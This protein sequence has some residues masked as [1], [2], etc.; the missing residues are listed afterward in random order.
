MCIA[1]VLSKIFCRASVPRRKAKNMKT[2]KITLTQDPVWGA[3]IGKHC[4][5]IVAALR[6]QLPPEG[7]IT[8]TCAND[9]TTT[10]MA[11]YSAKM[12]K[13]KI[14]QYVKIWILEFQV[15]DGSATVEIVE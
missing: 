1:S 3:Y 4:G 10:L 8:I 7:Q 13:H 15:R 14:A 11:P 6:R 9:G 5:D 12:E 2:L